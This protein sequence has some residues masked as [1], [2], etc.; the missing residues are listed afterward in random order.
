MQCQIRTHKGLA[1]RDTIHVPDMIP[2]IDKHCRCRHTHPFS[3]TL[4]WN[5]CSRWLRW[6]NSQYFADLV[7]S[8]T[9]PRQIVEAR[10][11]FEPLWPL[12][13][14]KL[15]ISR[16]APS[17]R[18]SRNAR[19]GYTVGTRAHSA[20]SMELSVQ[21]RLSACRPPLLSSPRAR[22]GG[23]RRISGMRRIRLRITRNSLHTSV[24]TWGTA[25]DVYTVDDE[26]HGP[27]FFWIPNTLHNMGLDHHRQSKMEV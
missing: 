25:A 13:T 14:R 21:P 17:A 22:H 4:L 24:C 23:R 15:L 8:W 9:K 10:V 1:S 3:D 5:S 12:K 2:R 6:N 27:P 18:I 11:G 7:L 16:P 20:A 19:A 26:Q